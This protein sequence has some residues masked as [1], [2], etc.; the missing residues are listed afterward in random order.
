MSWQ[1]FTLDVFTDQPF[2][3][4]PLAVFPWAAGLNGEQM[5]RLA[6]ELNLSETVFVFAAEHPG[7]ARR[8]RIFTPAA[9][10]PFAGHPTVGTAFLLATIGEVP[11]TGAEGTMIL[12]EGVG[13]VPVLV[14]TR[15]GQPCWS[16]LTAARAPTFAPLPV[17]VAVI[18]AALGVPVEEVLGEALAPCVAS[19]GVPFAFVQLRDRE[20]LGRLRLR[21]DVWEQVLEGTEAANLFV[22]AADDSGDS[23]YRARMFAPGLGVPEDPATGGAAVGLAGVLGRRAARDGQHGWLVHQ[24][25]EMGRPS[26]LEIEAEV[27]AGEVVATRVG[28][29]SVLVAEG[30]FRVP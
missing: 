19:C 14:R 8:V 10:L 12:E 4:N 23:D 7:N 3:G 28:G 27:R 17:G 25:F 1:F 21:R 24:G 26:R 22:F 9:E 2:G 20:G 13:P 29:P 11:I 6:A 18:A 16:Q 30:H 5:Q 15:G